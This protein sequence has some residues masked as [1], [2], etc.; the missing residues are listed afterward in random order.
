M[1]PYMNYPQYQDNRIPYLQQQIAYLES[2]LKGAEAMQHYQ[3]Q[4]QQ[5][6]VQQQMQNI[7]IPQQNQANGIRTFVV[8][9]F[10]SILAKDIPMDKTGAIFLNQD[11]TEM[12]IRR[13]DKDGTI[14]PI[15]FR[16]V[17]ESTS[18]GNGNADVSLPAVQKM[19]LG[20]SDEATQAFM[21]RFDELANRLDVMEQIL[22]RPAPTKQA[23]SRPKKEAKSESAGNDD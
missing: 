12:Q 6:Q 9:S 1:Q 23:A 19:E 16:R 13:W 17:E 4:I 21:Q 18:V 15:I 14:K 10:D 2:Q 20:L 22:N 8:D 11:E 3:Q 5:P 7:P